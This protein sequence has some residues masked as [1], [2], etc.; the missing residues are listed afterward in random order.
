MKYRQRY[1]AQQ[2]K[3]DLKRKMVFLGGLRQVG[4]TTLF[5]H[6]LGGEKDGYFIT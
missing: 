3:Q 5:R 4:K 2:I 6:I 1:L